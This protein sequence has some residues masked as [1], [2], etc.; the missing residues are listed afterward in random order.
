MP[1][2]QWSTG[3]YEICSKYVVLDVV[4]LTGRDSSKSYILSREK[5]SAYGSFC[6]PVPLPACS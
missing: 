4:Q 1:G 5:K 3:A 2:A 6:L